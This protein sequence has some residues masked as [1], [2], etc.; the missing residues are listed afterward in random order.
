MKKIVLFLDSLGRTIIGEDVSDAGYTKQLFVKNPAILHAAVDDAGKIKVSL[1]PVFFREFLSDWNLPT[2][3]SYNVERIAVEVNSTVLDEKLVNQYE[4][5][6][7]KRP[8]R[9]EA[10]KMYKQPDSTTAPE[11]VVNKLDL[12]EKKTS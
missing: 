9:E 3:F 11:P 1:L 6:W 7:E 4:K 12:F 2:V 10:R 5:I 8:S